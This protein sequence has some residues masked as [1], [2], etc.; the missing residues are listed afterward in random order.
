MAVIISLVLRV[1]DGRGQP[2]CI[3]LLR[4]VAADGTGSPSGDLS[5]RQAIDLADAS[6]PQMVNY[7]TITFEIGWGVQVINVLSPLPALTTTMIIDAA[8]QPG[9]LDSPIIALDG[10]DAGPDADGLTIAGPLARVVVEGLSIEHFSGSG[11]FIEDG[12]SNNT[13][14]GTALSS[15]NIIAFNG[16]DGVTVGT[17]LSDPCVNDEILGNAIFGNGLLGI[18]LGDN[19]VTPPGSGGQSGPNELQISPALTSA[20]TSISGTTST[21]TIAGTLSAAPTTTY[22]IELF[23][24][25]AAEP[26]KYPQAATFVTAVSVTTNASGAATFSVQLAASYIGPYIS[27]TATVSSRQH[28]GNLGRYRGLARSLASRFGHVGRARRRRGPGD[29]P[30]VEIDARWSR[31][32]HDLRRRRRDARR[33][34]RALPLRPDGRL[35]ANEH[36]RGAAPGRRHHRRSRRNHR[37]RRVRHRPRFAAAEYSGG[38][39][40]GI[41]DGDRP[42]GRGAVRHRGARVAKPAWRRTAAPN[43]T[44]PRASPR[45]SIR[46]CSMGPGR[47]QGPST[48]HPLR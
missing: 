20:K 22:H 14:G 17:S 38:A 7:R 35:A 13:I 36:R 40:G 34:R 39:V 1:G 41:G 4:R 5:L 28:V 42:R 46:L 27:A 18:D 9:Y 3:F 23:D 10:R 26:P 29:R 19:D 8:S 43:P 44:R 12:A 32:R 11:I 37:L 21:T 31:D 6:P 47:G 30:R 25:P 2:H 33:H 24:S 15:P 45:V 16:G 48:S